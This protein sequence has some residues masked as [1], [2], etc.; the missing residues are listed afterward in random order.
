M[1]GGT[2]ELGPAVHG[3]WDYGLKPT[4]GWHA[5]DGITLRPGVPLACLDQVATYLNFC[6]N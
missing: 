4:A 5:R 1:E 3:G 2:Q 6:S